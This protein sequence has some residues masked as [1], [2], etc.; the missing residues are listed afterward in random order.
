[1][2]RYVLVAVLLLPIGG[3]LAAQTMSQRFQQLYTFGDCGQP[4]CLTVNESVHGEHFVPSVTQGTHNMLAFVTGSI[5]ASLA[6]LPFTAGNGGE[7]FHFENGVP[8]ATSVSS[9]TLFSERAQTLGKGRVVAGANVTGSSMDNIRGVPL[10]NLTARF[11]HQNVGAAAYGDPLFEND[12]IEVHTDLRLN[13][14]V[15]SFFASYGLLDNVDVGILV[16]LVRSSLS[17]HSVAQVIPYQEPT[18]HLFGTTS[19]PSEFADAYSSGSATGLGDI[20]LRVKA[21]VYQSRET[22][23]A[24]VGDVRLP[25]GDSANFLGSGGTSVRVVGVVSG[26]SGNF[27]PHLNAGYAYRKGNNQTNSVLATLGFDQLFSQNVTLAAD[28]IT[29]TQLGTSKLLLPQPVIYDLPVRRR[30]DLTDIPDIRDNTIDASIGLKSQFA[31]SYRAVTNLLLPLNVGGMRA[32]FIW[33]IGAER[34]F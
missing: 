4:L 11:A 26:R 9:G 24:V 17:G 23:F 34:S 33:T 25:T 32:R 19:S 7:T 10:N 14:L 22:G 16:P 15:T 1:M 31:G 5:G 8:V 30:V 29:D 6:N 21:N 18:P 3:R 20:A 13:L 28:F 27:A 2:R 12:L